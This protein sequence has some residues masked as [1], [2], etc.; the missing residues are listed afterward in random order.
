[1]ELHNLTPAKGSIGRAKKRL[2]RGQGSTDGGTSSRGHKGAKS[3]SGYTQKLGF[4]G[5]Q[6]PL[7]RRMP[8][9]GF[10]NFHRV[11]FVGLNLEKIQHLID[12]R[13]LTEV[14]VEGLRENGLL[15][16][17]KLVKIL[18]SGELKTKVN[19]SVHAISEA[20][21]AKIEALGGTVTIAKY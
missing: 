8:K 17:T 16:K 2:G 14:T 9:V 7:Q 13:G 3:R 20:A 10:K 6:M 19:V 4:E 15:G 18:A 5:G 11:S 21:K 1:M 12:N